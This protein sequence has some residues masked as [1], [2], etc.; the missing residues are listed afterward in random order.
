ME[1]LIFALVAF[2]KLFRP[3]EKKVPEPLQFRPFDVQALKHVYN[4]RVEP[5][6]RPSAR[7]ESYAAQALS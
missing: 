6:D 2:I 5:S 7:P 1:A 4:G 3:D